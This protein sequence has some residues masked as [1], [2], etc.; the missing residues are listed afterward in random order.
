MDPALHAALGVA[1]FLAIFGALVLRPRGVHEALVAGV[2][3]IAVV[4]LG[5]VSGP[6][7]VETIAAQWNIF[8]F[9]LGLML[10][11]AVADQAGFFDSVAVLAARIAGGSVPRLYLAVFAMGVGITTFLSNDATALVVTPV[12][13][14]LATRLRLAVLPFMFACTFIAD[15]ASFVL[16]VSN[17][18]N[19]LIVDAF[20]IDLS[21]FLRHLLLPALFCVVANIFV[22]WIRFRRE[23]RGRY[24]PA[25]L[26]DI[27]PRRRN[28]KFLRFVVVS[29][30]CIVVAYVV[31]ASAQLP[32]SAVALPGALLLLLGAKAHGELRPKS[33][34]AEVSWE[35][36]VFIAGLFVIAR[37]ALDLGLS[38]ALAGVLSNAGSTS[39][40]STAA[41]IF[42]TAV[43]AN[44]LT[45]V[46]MAV[47]MVAA[48][49][50]QHLPAA[51]AAGAGYATIVGVDLGPNFT[52]LGS[53]ATVLWLQ[54]LRRRGLDV[55]AKEYLLLGFSVVPLMLAGC[56]ILLWWLD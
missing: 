53:L 56:A 8:A 32:L 22:F 2:G 10:I 25:S 45:N 55:S 48:I 1:L 43:G 19:V 41:L 11:S 5:F 33:I 14:A 42:T 26:S 44:L 34:Y 51:R 21:S 36:L 46:S 23:L 9:F 52:T 13:Y 50:A 17:P 30:A 15:T 28:P 27:F 35:I 39:L 16:P 49:G 4:S 47:V 37:G 6:E 12:I 20:G 31:V 40:G 38:G 18:L 7:A 3:A 54:I 29:L 24:D